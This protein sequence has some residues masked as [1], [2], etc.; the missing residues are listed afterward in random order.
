MGAIKGEEV[1][2][3]IA[4]E[5]DGDANNGDAGITDEGGG[6][7]GEFEVKEEHEA[8]VRLSPTYPSEGA[9]Q[10]VGCSNPPNPWR[11][12]SSS[13]GWNYSVPLKGVHL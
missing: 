4:G 5:V 8:A 2:Q 7:G 3:E 13:K 11:G 6:S 10:R 9:I 1:E 12:S